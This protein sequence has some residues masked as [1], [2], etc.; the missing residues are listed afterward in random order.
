MELWLAPLERVTDCA[1][2]TLCYQ[3]GADMTM[4]PFVKIDSFL[5]EKPKATLR[6]DVLSDTPTEVQLL[7][8]NIKE[9]QKF[10]EWFNSTDSFELPANYEGA[11]S[12]S[13]INFERNITPLKRTVNLSN[14][15]GFNLNV[16]CPDP[17][18]VETGRGAALVK[19][20][21]RIC[22]L[23]EILK[24]TDLPVSIKMRLGANAREKEN[25]VYLR[26]VQN[27]EADAFIIHARH[28]KESYNEPA[29]ASIF[30]ELVAT[31]KKIIAN[32]DIKT[33]DDVEHFKHVGAAGAMIGREA[34]LNPQ[35]FSRIKGKSRDTSYEKIRAEYQILA[36]MYDIP[37]QNYLFTYNHIGG[38]F[39]HRV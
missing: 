2:R 4:T 12:Q 5:R 35:I 23:V 36:R 18:I 33:K 17:Y 15:S 11:L 20:T 31:G 13:E 14:V 28:G 37:K 27:C 8:N 7:T 22:D 1:F 24:K 29:D 6:F 10:T 39:E 26:L 34:V 16:G 19:R 38:V 30:P 32:C 25:K 21:K 3:Y 9:T